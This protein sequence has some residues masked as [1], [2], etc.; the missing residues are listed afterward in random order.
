MAGI[1]HGYSKAPNSE[2]FFATDPSCWGAF[3]AANRPVLPRTRDAAAGRH[4]TTIAG[5][6]EQS[7]HVPF[8]FTHRLPSPH[9]SP[10]PLPLGRRAGCWWGSEP[11][12]K[13]L[14]VL[15]DLPQTEIAIVKMTNAFRRQN[16]LQ[17][18]RPNAAQT[19]A[20]RAYAECLPRRCT[21]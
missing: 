11:P 20:A 16:A 15:P 10:R 12:A 7:V 1:S 18:L 9:S 21:H 4:A 3:L 17:E 6:A 13:G 19:T 5:H 2:R 8:G 14:P